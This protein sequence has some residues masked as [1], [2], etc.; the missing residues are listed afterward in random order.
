MSV[1][2]TK[3]NDTNV[4]DSQVELERTPEEVAVSDY[5]AEGDRASVLSPSPISASSQTTNLGGGGGEGGGVDGHYLDK[6]DNVSGW[7]SNTCDRGKGYFIVAECRNGHRFAKELVCNKEW[8][9]VCG[10]AG[11]FAHMRR[12]ARWLPKIQQFDCMGYFVFTIPLELRSRYRTKK[13]LAKLGHDVQELLKAFGCFRGLRRWHW[14]GD[15]STRF[16]PH[17]NCLVDGGF[18][19]PRKLAAIKRGYA[20]LLGVELA[21]VNYHYR[22][23]AGKMVH[24]LRYV[25]RA[26]F[27]EYDWDLEMALELRG[28]RNMVVWGRGRWDDPAVWSLADLGGKARAEVEG[29]DIETINSLVDKVCPVCGES[30]VWGEALPVGLLT[31]VSKQPLGAGY[32]RLADMKPPPV[33]D[34]FRPKYPLLSYLLNIRHY[35][36][37]AAKRQAEAEARAEA[38]EYQGWWD[39]LVNS[40]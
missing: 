10:Q 29:L 26:T 34:K 6:V 3:Q 21:D 30:V 14:F 38:E 19:S 23:S 28:F 36:I 32:W 2:T 24:T 5:M 15:K 35:K 16:H 20:S 8:C 17:L 31:I 7:L 39:S 18:V 4:L 37:E 27:R 22:L 13:A 9:G 25:C 11:S 40:N 12:F 1:T 33:Q